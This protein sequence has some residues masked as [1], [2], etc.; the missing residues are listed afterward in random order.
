MFP[1]LLGHCVLLLRLKDILRALLQ[2]KLE[3]THDNSSFACITIVADDLK[4][5]SIRTEKL[6][7][8]TQSLLNPKAPESHFASS[9]EFP[10]E[11]NVLL[12]SHERNI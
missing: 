4:S 11:G 7:Q 3:E 1:S 9:C 12:G 6:F 5:N 2:S 8:S 10:G